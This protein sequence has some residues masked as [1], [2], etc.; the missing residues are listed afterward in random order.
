MNK[1]DNELELVQTFEISELGRVTGAHECIEAGTDEPARPAAKHRL[2]AEQVCLGFLA[3]SCFDYANTAATDS[4]GPGKRRFSC[5]PG[6]ITINCKQ[7][8]HTSTAHELT[9]HHRAEAF[10]RHHHNVDIVARDK[11]FIMNRKAMGEEERLA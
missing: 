11:R 1:I 9:T 3:K 2:L 7:T 6:K 4:F 5:L 8:G 10:R